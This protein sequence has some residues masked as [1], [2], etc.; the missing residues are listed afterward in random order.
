M[1]I[2][3]IQN[4]P[5]TNILLTKHEALLGIL[6]HAHEI[7]SVCK[8]EV[9]QIQRNKRSSTANTD[10]RQELAERARAGQ[11]LVRVV[12]KQSH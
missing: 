12:L 8:H 6:Q 11:A 9:H 3:H 7:I 10:T 2:N 5:I 1:G 4:T